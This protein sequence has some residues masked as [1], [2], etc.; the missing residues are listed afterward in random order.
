MVRRFY[1]SRLF[2]LGVP[3]L[4]FLL[5][6]WWDSGRYE[7]SVYWSEKKWE[8][9]AGVYGGKAHFCLSWALGGTVFMEVHDADRVEWGMA[10]GDVNPRARRFDFVEGF[11][12]ETDSSADYRSFDLQVGLWMIVASYVAL[13]LGAVVVWERRKMRVMRDLTDS[14]ME[15]E[16]VR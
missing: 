9:F 7:S 2:W 3:G 16:V 13:W 15:K 1:K 4:V 14:V 8:V 10:K 11:A 12:L 6:V 5:W